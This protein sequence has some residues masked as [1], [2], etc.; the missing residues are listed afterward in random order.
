MLGSNK[1]I[2]WQQ[3]GQDIDIDLS[4]FGIND[5]KNV[6]MNTLKITQA[7]AVK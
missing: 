4:V 2:N 7:S 3:Q 5:V 6:Y 1:V